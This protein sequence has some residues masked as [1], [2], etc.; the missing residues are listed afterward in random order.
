MIEKLLEHDVSVQSVLPFF[1]GRGFH[2]QVDARVFGVIPSTY[3]HQIYQR[4]A[5]R[6]AGVDANQDKIPLLF[7]PGGRCAK[8]AHRSQL[9]C[10][11]QNIYQAARLWRLP[12]S[13]NLKSGK[14]KIPLSIDELSHLGVDEILDLASRPRPLPRRGPV[15]KREKAR[16]LFYWAWQEVREERQEGRSLPESQLI[17]KGF[18]VIYLDS[19]GKPIRGKL[20]RHIAHA[21]VQLA[22]KAH[23]PVVLAIRKEGGSV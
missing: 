2:V 5:Y 6:L 7:G 18:D 20:P 8:A 9:P 14:Y 10:M 4:L 22:R 1:S 23:C 16:Q 21:A 17:Q 3:L 12:G 19:T 13:V 11:D 15:E